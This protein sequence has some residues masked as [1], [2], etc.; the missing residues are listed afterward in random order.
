MNAK[1]P[2]TSVTVS[3]AT[4]GAVGPSASSATVAPEIGR[5]CGPL[6]MPLIANVPCS[7]LLTTQSPPAES[8]SPASQN[9]V[10]YSSTTPS[11][12]TGFGFAG[13]G[14]PSASSGRPRHSGSAALSSEPPHAAATAASAT[15][16]IAPW[17]RSRA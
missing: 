2:S 8:V 6:M 3:A 13:C 9:S 16:S 14:S 5:P 1:A 7:V 12:G 4:F 15:R 10:S 17:P 11:S